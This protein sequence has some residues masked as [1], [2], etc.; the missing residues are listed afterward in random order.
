MRMP[1]WAY[2]YLCIFVAATITAVTADIETDLDANVPIE[3]Q[4]LVTW[5]ETPAIQKLRKVSD[6]FRN[7]R[8]VVVTLPNGTNITWPY[9]NG[10]LPWH[11]PPSNP[12]QYP[13]NFPPPQPPPHQPP[14]YQPPPPHSHPPPSNNP[15]PQQHPTTT[16]P[17]PQPVKTCV[18]RYVALFQGF[19]GDCMDLILEL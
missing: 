15:P 13:P 11:R 3:Y 18:D 6:N 8:Q 16:T 17:A 10:T 2:A 19:N 4:H 12:P 14:P 5:V 9:G 1:Y 7:G